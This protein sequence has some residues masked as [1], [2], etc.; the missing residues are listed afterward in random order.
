LNCAPRIEACWACRLSQHFD[1]I[2]GIFKQDAMRR[3]QILQ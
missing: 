1:C 3:N 2:R